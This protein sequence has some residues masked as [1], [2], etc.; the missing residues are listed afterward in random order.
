VQEY[1]PGDSLKDLLVQGKKFSEAEV[2]QI[3]TEILEI[4]VYLHELNPAVLHRDI[5]PSNIIYG[6]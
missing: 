2:K 4:L 6:N 5:K 1:I 3:A